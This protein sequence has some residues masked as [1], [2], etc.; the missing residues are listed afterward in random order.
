M[1]P[2]RR[3]PRSLTWIPASSAEPI[4]KAGAVPGTFLTVRGS[5]DPARR[6]RP[7]CREPVAREARRC[8]PR[9]RRDG[10]PR[11]GPGR[12]RRSSA[13]ASRRRW[14]RRTRGGSGGVDLAATNSPEERRAGR[15]GGRCDRRRVMAVAPGEAVV[16]GLH[17]G[18]LA[19]APARRR[20]QA[21]ASRS[22]VRPAAPSTDVHVACRARHP[23]G[24]PEA[25]MIAVHVPL[26]S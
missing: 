11:S 5:A 10:G 2:R 3:E 12:R 19:R 16:I 23:P 14:R 1:E 13:P 21:L 15:S 6:L 17:A 22:S 26:V 18:S 9:R 20:G 7:Q 25:A 4:L 24:G 8:A